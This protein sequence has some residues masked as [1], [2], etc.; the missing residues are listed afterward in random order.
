MVKKDLELPSLETNGASHVSSHSKRNLLSIVVPMF[1][2]EQCVSETI[3]RLNALRDKMIQKVEIEF[4]FVNDGST[5][6]TGLS[7]R[8]CAG[9]NPHIKLIELSRNFGHQ[10]AATAGLDAAKG[11]YVAIIDG[12][13]Q[14]P[15]EKIEDM[16]L[17]ALEGYDVVYGK[18]LK[19]AGETWF[20]KLTA[21]AF[22][23][24]MGAISETPIPLDTGDFR[25]V[26]RR[27]V[28][29]LGTMRERNRFLRG[30]V[31]WVG[32]NSVPLEYDRDLRPAGDSKY[33]MRKMIGLAADAITSFSSKP[34]LFVIR[35]GGM[36][37]LLGV[38]AAFYLL[39]LR[40]FTD[41]VVPGITSILITILVFNGLQI[42]IIGVIGAYVSKIFE[43]IKGRP[44]YV[45]EN[46]VNL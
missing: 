5:D 4:I 21:T 11:D 24:F 10:I 6:Q 19:R 16:Y 8:K 41:S 32:F 13:L 3:R 26:S 33:P 25:L 27:V 14:D 31:P 30:M 15:P 38:L 18:R 45:V 17:L 37:L 1:N 20:K 36:M 40:L 23:R 42:F 22:Y 35:L 44:L 9:N 43:E 2:E 28:D 7:I 46:V 29:V 12:D 39:Y 34:L